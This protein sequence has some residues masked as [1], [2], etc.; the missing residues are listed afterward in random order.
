[1]E[2]VY[3]VNTGDYI[4]IRGKTYKHLINEGY[5]VNENK[6]LLPPVKTTTEKVF[7]LLPL[8]L[9]LEPNDLLSLYITNK[10]F[11]SLNNQKILDLLTDK[12]NLDE[13]NS[14]TNFIKLYN[15]SLINPKI[16]YLYDLENNIE[17]PSKSFLAAFKSDK[18]NIT[19][20]IRAVLFNW[21]I[22]F[23]RF[24]ITFAKQQY[25]FFGLVATLF[26]AHLSQYTEMTT[27]E[28]QLTIAACA[29]LVE[30]M[31]LDDRAKIEDYI[32]F[33]KDME[34]EALQNKI[35]LVFNSLHGILIRPSTV[36]F[37][38]MNDKNVRDLVNISYIVPELITY[39]PSMI[40]ETISYI[41]YGKYKIYTL[42][43]L[44][45]ICKSL[46]GYVTRL[47][48]TSFSNFVKMAA[49]AVKHLKHGCGTEMTPI[50]EST[51]KYTEPWHLG[52]YEKIK[53]IAGG[54]YGK[55]TK[56]KR[57]ECTK[58]FVIKTNINPESQE[59]LLEI[60]ILKQLKDENVIQLCSYD[61]NGYKIKMYLPFM[62]YTIKTLINNNLFNFGNLTIYFKQI[63]AGLKACHDNDIIHRDIKIENIIYDE[64][65]DLFKIIDFGISVTYSSFRYYLDPIMACTYDYRAPE[66]LLGDQHYNE[67]VDIWAVGVV[68]YYIL[69]KKFIIADYNRGDDLGALNDIFKIF[70][71]PVE[72]D[73]QYF[74]SRQH[75]RNQT[76]LNK[77]FGQYPFILQCFIFDYNKRPSANQLLI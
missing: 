16:S 5:Y 57:N 56:I 4:N 38:D 68:F 75:P 51:F 45:P 12:Y 58:D 10:Q 55:I 47:H 37:I 64:K 29:Y 33:N 73:H 23:I 35:N 9:A 30:Y 24:K 8:V 48:L 44:N 17:L 36:F 60:S 46:V 7:T 39:K 74:K 65:N 19:K 22:D 41:V 61:I 28:A 42:A 25:E 2:T 34:Y 11:K 14:F 3:N 63:I 76:Y 66:A 26:D 15:K 67:K 13:V 18:L 59:V 27:D 54:A 43:E 40:A 53:V 62:Q 52:N 72:L 49:T 77:V 31:I 70:G 50:K 71:T 1:M 21:L 69:T 32:E 20:N 6:L